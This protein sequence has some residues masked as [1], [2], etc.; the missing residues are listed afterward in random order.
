MPEKKPNEDAKP[1]GA[2]KSRRQFLQVA[3]AAALGT[4][5]TPDAARAWLDHAGWLIVLGTGAVA[6]TRPERLAPGRASAAG[7]EE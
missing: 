4:F 7:G 5:L 6:A 2:G 3:G 1:E